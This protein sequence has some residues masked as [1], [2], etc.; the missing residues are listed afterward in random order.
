MKW[1]MR[2]VITHHTNC[3]QV[4]WTQFIHY[5]DEVMMNDSRTC[6]WPS[7]HVMCEWVWWQSSTSITLWVWETSIVMSRGVSW[8]PLLGGRQKS[9]SRLADWINSIIINITQ[10]ICMT[11]IQ[12]ILTMRWHWCW[13]SLMTI[14]WRV[15]MRMCWYKSDE[16]S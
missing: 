2:G 4:I 7:S 14:T 15:I 16:L 5:L 10:L 1:W 8:R 6:H 11:H 9:K 13:T 12:T 3:H